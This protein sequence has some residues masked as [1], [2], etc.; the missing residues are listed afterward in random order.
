MQS[1]KNWIKNVCAIVQNNLKTKT[2]NSS[3][4]TLLRFG[5]RYIVW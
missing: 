1:G 3:Y 5:Y 2:T 4:T